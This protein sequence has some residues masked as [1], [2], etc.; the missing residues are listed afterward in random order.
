MRL[1]LLAIVIATA[2]PLQTN[3]ADIKVLCVGGVQPA[4]SILIPQFE[5]ASGHKV[6]IA[7]VSPGGALRDRVLT[8]RDVDVALVPSPVL[9]DIEKAGKIVPGSR[10]EIARTPLA[11]GIRA[12]APKPDLSSPDAVKRAVLAAK[13]I[14]LSDPKAN[15]PIGI[16]FMRVADKF[17]FGSELKAR[18]VLIKG[19][20][21]AVAE[22]VARGEA[23]MTVTLMS[24][25]LSVRGA[26]VAGPLP[27]EMQNIIVTSAIL[28]PGGK[29][30]EGGRAL[31]MFLRT[32]EAIKVFKSKGQDP[33]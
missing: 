4:I 28:V 31:I 26:E 29:E 7:Y 14:A 25:I 1:P 23:E 18:T 16:Y 32:P 20:G 30:L 8:D 11:V 27:A 24:E 3:A 2:M 15:S 22:A 5:R 19:G 9:A 6:S 17:G 33:G 21:V 10:V 13:S 12:G